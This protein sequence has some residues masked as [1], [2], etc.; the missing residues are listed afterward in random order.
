MAQ[1]LS[2]LSNLR[3]PSSAFSLRPADPAHA[4]HLLRRLLFHVRSA[5]SPD[6]TVGIKLG[7]GDF[8][9][10]GLDVEEA[11]EQVR[12]ARE[13]RVV[14][15]RSGTTSEEGYDFVDISGGSYANPGASMILSASSNH[16]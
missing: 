6:F 1:F 13:M 4:H 7:C 2:P 9:A 14:V 3:P 5:T 10:G 8:T 12:A 16:L 11:M 15:K